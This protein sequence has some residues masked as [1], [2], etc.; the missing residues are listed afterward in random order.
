MKWNVE[1]TVGCYQS[2]L[3]TSQKH[4]VKFECFKTCGM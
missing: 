2:P 1:S 3:G 4:S